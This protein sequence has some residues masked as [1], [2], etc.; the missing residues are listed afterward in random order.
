MPF[1]KREQFFRKAMTALALDWPLVIGR[2]PDAIRAIPARIDVTERCAGN[3]LQGR[4]KPSADNTVALM[5]NFPEVA[6][7]ILE[8]AGLNDN[9]SLTAVQRRKLA[10]A[11]KLLEAFGDE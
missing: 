6:D 5:A 7:A 2:I 8:A 11:R 9:A 3:W 10:E 1:R 4:A